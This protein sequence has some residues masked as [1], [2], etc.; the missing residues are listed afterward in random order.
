MSDVVDPKT[1]TKHSSGDKLESKTHYFLYINGVSTE[2][3]KKDWE[4]SWKDYHER[5]RQKTDKEA[6]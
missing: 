3:P 6:K 5:V 2:V 4:K 1:H